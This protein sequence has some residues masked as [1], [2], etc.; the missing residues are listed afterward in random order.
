MRDESTRALKQMRDLIYKSD[1][2]Y[3]RVPL[4]HARVRELEFCIVGFRIAGSAGG[5]RAARTRAARLRR[6]SCL[7]G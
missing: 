1:A 7:G 4:A 6:S 2:I 5:A 3:K